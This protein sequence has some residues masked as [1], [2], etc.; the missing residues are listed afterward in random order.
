MSFSSEWEKTY[1]ASQ[2]LS[3]WPWSDLVYYVCRYAK[4]TD[5]VVSRVLELGC[6]VGANIPFFLA[7]PFDYSSVE[8]SASAV[9]VLHRAYPQLVNK[10]VVGDFTK[11]IPFSGEFDLIIDRVSLPHNSTEA[12]LNCLKVCFS[13]LKPGGKMIGIDWFSTEHKDSKKG[14]EVDLFTRTNLPSDSHLHGLGC[15]H[16]FDQ[17]HLS[18]LLQEAGFIIQRLEHKSHDLYIPESQAGRLA[19]WHFVALKPE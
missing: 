5:G 4:P 11:E 2:H 8:G 16:F 9:S 12:I 1:Q 17:K 13:K 10:I 14:D 15:V 6:G 19:W 3:V 18:Y 7:N